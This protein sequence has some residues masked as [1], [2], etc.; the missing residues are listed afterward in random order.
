MLSRSLSVTTESSY[1]LLTIIA[2]MKDSFNLSE[3]R[4]ASMI[5]HKFELG[6]ATGERDEHDSP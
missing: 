2:G 1:Q 5:S 4:H 6:S 3:L